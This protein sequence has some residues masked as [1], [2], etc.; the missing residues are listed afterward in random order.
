MERSRKILVVASFAMA[1]PLLLGSFYRVPINPTFLLAPLVGA[2]FFVRP[3]TL[4]HL[5]FAIAVM[6]G[7]VSIVGANVIAPGN[8]F[9]NVT[10]LGMIMFIAGFWFLGRAAMK[11]YDRTEIIHWLAVWSSVFLIVITVPLLV[12]GEPV[13]AMNP[14]GTVFVNVHFAGLPVFATFGINSLAPV[15]AVQASII[16]AAAFCARRAYLPFFAVALACAVFLTVGTESR[17]AMTSLALLALALAVFAWRDSS[18]WRV[19]STMA[20]ALCIGLVVIGSRGLGENRLV[21]SAQEVAELTTDVI[22][23]KPA[24]PKRSTFKTELLESAP[25]DPTMEGKAAIEKRVDALGSRRLTLWV[26]A[27]DEWR[28]HPLIGTGFASYGR[29]DPR[30]A[31]HVGA[32]YPHFYILTIFWLGGVVFAV[33]Y[34]GFLG[35]GLAAAMRGIDQTPGHFF[36][37]IAVLLLLALPSFAWDIMIIPFAGSLG[38]FLL[39]IL[40][41]KESK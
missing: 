30:H 13:R 25:K 2:A 22:A 17:S 7:L 5:A 15:F 37:A 8:V 34:F 10:S 38:W 9:G 33:P 14:D 18:R 35:F 19:S 12:T 36:T 29:Y 26:A 11:H 23:T 27:F 21:T 20:A 16:C 40:N 31:G 28:D 39:G 4:N 41:R 24:S 32:I 1:V 3:W 6:A